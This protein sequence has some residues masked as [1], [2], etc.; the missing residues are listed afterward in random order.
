MR[1]YVCICIPKILV[2]ASG[3]KK[4]KKEEVHMQKI[5]SKFSLLIRSKRHNF[6]LHHKQN[7]HL[8]TFCHI[9]F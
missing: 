6:F 3:Q 7:E 4:R 5:S 9:G 8:F 2:L 1:N